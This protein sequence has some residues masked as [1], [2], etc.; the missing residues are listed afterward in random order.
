METYRVK[1]D[2]PRHHFLTARINIFEQNLFMQ[3][4]QKFFEQEGREPT[5]SE[6]LRWII[7]TFHAA[8]V[9]GESHHAETI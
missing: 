5:D 4:K 7:T 3:C 9:S 1:I 8:F 2:M 6:C